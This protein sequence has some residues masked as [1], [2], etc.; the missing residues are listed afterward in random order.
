MPVS[1]T[2]IDNKIGAKRSALAA[3]IE[4]RVK[5]FGDFD[6]LTAKIDGLQAKDSLSD[7]ESTDLKSTLEAQRAKHAEVNAISDKIRNEEAE[8]NALQ[9]QRELRVEANRQ[10]AALVQ[11]QRRESTP[12]QPTGSTGG[13]VRVLPPSREQIQHDIAHIF[14]VG[15]QAHVNRVTPQQVCA[16]AVG[17]Q[18]RNDRLEAAFTQASNGSIIPP[19]YIPELIEFLRPASVLRT[20]EGVRQVDMPNGTYNQPRQSGAASAAYVGELTS[21]ATS[22]QTTNNVTMVAKKLTTMVVVSGEA[23]RHSNPNAD[24][25]IRDDLRRVVGEREDITFIRATQTSTVPG[26]L[27]WFAD[28]AS[29]SIAANATVNLA[30]VTADLGKLRRAIRNQNVPFRNRYF[31]FHPNVEQTLMDMR[32]DNGNLG[33]PEMERGLLRGTKYLTTTQIPINLGGGTNATEVYYFEASEFMIGD[34]PTMDLQLSLEAAYN[35]GAGVVSAFQMDAG[36]FRLIREHDTAMRHNV[37]VAYL[38]G[39]TWS[40]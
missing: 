20:A 6:S 1:L 13:N 16:G 7:E 25:M 2:E 23:L 8:L 19:G 29:Q 18:F 39:P 21:I 38:S 3:L 4:T 28:Q 11:P 37:S 17:D 10:E 33:F 12:E 14:R 9:G 35:D 40:V 31:L 30:N 27:K 36:V 26:G 15:Y 34:T 22:Q 5:A 32:D 24:A